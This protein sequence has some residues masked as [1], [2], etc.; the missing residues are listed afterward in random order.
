[1]GVY[2]GAELPLIFPK[3]W[4]NDSHPDDVRASRHLMT[5]WKA[6]IHNKEWPYAEGEE[7]CWPSY[8][9]EYVVN[10]FNCVEFQSAHHGI[11]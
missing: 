8:D 5:L 1:M 3:G 9:T 7:Y 11:G 6:H 2:H 4:T 10:F